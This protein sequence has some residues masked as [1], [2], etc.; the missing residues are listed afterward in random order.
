MY[1]INCGVKLADTEKVCPLCATRVFHPDL[2]REPARPLY[3]PE[4]SPMIAPGSKVG[5]IIF[6]ALFL[7]PIFIVLV[8]DLQLNGKV[9][10]SGYVIGS[11]LLCYEF[12]VLP[13]W[14]RKPNPIIFV[15]C[16]FAA[17]TL[18]LLYISLATRGH[19]FLSFAFPVTAGAGLIVTAVVVLLRCTRLGKLY[20]L[21]GASILWGGLMLLTEFLLYVTFEAVSFLG[22]SL[23]PLIF[24][25]LLGILLIVLAIVRPA[26]QLM[27]RK[28]FL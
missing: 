20:V 24:F 6:T 16:G 27:E 17:V 7:L 8:C 14:F 21:G 12:F 11:L 5:V 23:Y 1:C 9:V 28:F 22:W 25:V 18:F 2:T 3:P 13:A 10:W 19:W 26:R 15:P 4:V